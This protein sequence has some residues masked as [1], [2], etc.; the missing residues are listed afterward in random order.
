[1]RHAIPKL[2]VES[3]LPFTHSFSKVPAT[4]AGTTAA[5]TA[6]ASA[7]RAQRK[8]KAMRLFIVS[9]LPSVSCAGAA[10]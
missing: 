5:V 1:M 7:R 2:T 6:T 8:A 4:A 10:R 9:P 3:I